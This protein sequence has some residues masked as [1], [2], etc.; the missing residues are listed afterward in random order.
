MESPTVQGW[1]RLKLKMREGFHIGG[2]FYN[3][4]ISKVGKAEVF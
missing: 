4:L 2:R 1:K 3:Q